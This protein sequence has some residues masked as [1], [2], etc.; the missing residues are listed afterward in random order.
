MSLASDF[1]RQERGMGEI[2]DQG[3]HQGPAIRERPLCPSSPAFHIF[4]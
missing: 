4:T 1:H 2:G 3:E